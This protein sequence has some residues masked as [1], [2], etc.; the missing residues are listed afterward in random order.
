MASTTGSTGSPLP[1]PA[2]GRFESSLGTDLGDVRVH[3]GAAS[4]GAAEGL[5]ARAFATGQD[6]H[7][8]AGQY[9]PDD[10]FGMHLLAHEVAHT[11]QQRS[12]GGG[13]QTKLEVSRPGD[14]CELEADRA[15]DAMVTGAPASITGSAAQVAR[16][17][18]DGDG[19]AAAA[20]PAASK[21]GFVAFDSHGKWKPAEV[22]ANLKPVAED[23]RRAIEAGP[24]EVAR[25]CVALRARVKAAPDLA[26][27]KKDEF[28]RALTSRITELVYATPQSPLTYAQLDQVSEWNDT[29]PAGAQAPPAADQPAARPATPAAAA[30]ADPVEHHALELASREGYRVPADHDEIRNHA[31][32]TAARGTGTNTRANQVEENNPQFPGWR[33]VRD[34]FDN[35]VVAVK[36]DGTGTQYVFKVETADTGTSLV[37]DHKEELSKLRVNALAY[38]DQAGMGK[39]QEDE[40]G[41]R[42]RIQRDQEI[43][44]EDRAKWGKEHP[45]EYAAYQEALRSWQQAA[46]DT[47]KGSRPPAPPAMPQGMPGNKLTTA[48]TNWP[49]PVY[50]A[51]GGE[52]KTSFSFT[53]PTGHPGWRDAKD[54]PEGPK[55]GDPYWLFDV[56][57]NRTAHMGV[58]KS[59]VSAGTTADG[60]PL[61]MWTVTDGGQGGYQRIQEVQERTRGPYN[62]ATLLFSSSI[63]EAGQSKGSRRLTGW[64][65]I[66]K[67]HEAETGGGQ[68]AAAP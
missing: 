13:A 24:E 66:D 7:F 45:G 31:A 38:L 17:P 6:I 2:R 30:P 37:L 15:A 36:P 53:P 12:G 52:M 26:A 8:G 49:A 22:F 16:V 61:Q 68:D 21:P 60:A 51:A 48:C 62:P 34:P 9:Q 18:G 50:H 23:L 14:P 46:K 28:A 43:G 65:D 19:A 29:Y 59:R 63:A 64:I 25:L 47:P 35:T 20:A 56:D 1:D 27:D 55:P 57:R 5:G 33:F 44:D 41:R 42:R 10:P 54:H 40:A 58:F 39:D 3:T 11:V 4:A 32:S 67:E